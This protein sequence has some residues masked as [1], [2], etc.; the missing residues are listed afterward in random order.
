MSDSV[1]A[2]VDNVAAIHDLYIDVNL[3]Q[4]ETATTGTPEARTLAQ[5]RGDWMRFW[6]ELEP[7]RRYKALMIVAL[8]GTMHGWR[9][10][11]ICCTPR[12]A[13]ATWRRSAK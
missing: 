6:A 3:K 9:A 13:S 4:W 11:F 2:A 10:R 5:V 8:P 12:Q 1:R 7:Y